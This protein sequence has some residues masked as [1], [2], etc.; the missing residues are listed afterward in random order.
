M[1][2][3]M[4]ASSRHA[5]TITRSKLGLRCWRYILF[6]FNKISHPPSSF[7][8]TYRPLFTKV[9][10]LKTTRRQHYFS[11]HDIWQHTQTVLKQQFLTTYVRSSPNLH[12]TPRVVLGAVNNRHRIHCPTPLKCSHQVLIHFR[13]HYII[14]IYHKVDILKTK[15]FLVFL[16]CSAVITWYNGGESM[17]NKS[18]HGLLYYLHHQD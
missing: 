8:G 16:S 14:L 12:P 17:A 7:V 1:S 4:C 13:H 18:Q 9:S 3:T 11:T 10:T 6:N 15:Y 2:H 5:T